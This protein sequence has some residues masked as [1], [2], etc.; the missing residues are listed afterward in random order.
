[1]N[2]YDTFQVIDSESPIIVKYISFASYDGTP[3]EFY[4]N[5]SSIKQ[6]K[7]PSTKEPIQMELKNNFS[8][9]NFNTT[10]IQSDTFETVMT[11][12]FLDKFSVLDFGILSI[13]IFIL[14]INIIQLYCMYLFSK[15]L[16][17]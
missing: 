1:M 5:C 7:S 14:W 2:K 13:N 8:T 16:D 12:G 17:S 10:K 3:M 11:E 6:R 9:E 4:Y 15:Y